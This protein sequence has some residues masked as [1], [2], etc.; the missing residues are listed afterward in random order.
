VPG[1][2]RSEAWEV[3]TDH[4]GGT[5][6]YYEES[7]TSQAVLYS[8]LVYRDPAGRGPRQPTLAL[9]LYRHP[10]M[11]PAELKA[12]WHRTAVD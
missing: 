3:S 9:V 1:S 2:H 8:E 6:T 4:K 12:W 7:T 5:L 11:S 10:T